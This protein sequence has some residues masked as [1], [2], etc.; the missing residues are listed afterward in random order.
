MRFSLTKKIF[1]GYL[2]LIS[3]LLA[4][5]GYGGVT[6]YQ[7]TGEYLYLV[8][9]GVPVQRD[10]YALEELFRLQTGNEQKFYVVGSP[11]IAERFR[12]QD[13]EFEQLAAVLISQVPTPAERDA[14]VRVLALHQSYSSA[15]M[16]NMADWEAGGDGP[17]EVGPGYDT[18]PLIEDMAVGLKALS[19]I[20]RETRKAHLADTQERG[21][22]AAGT[23]LVLALLAVAG[24]LAA[25][26]G[27]SF[28]L[29]RPVWRLKAATEQ[30]ALGIFDRKVPVES[31][32]EI[33]DL[34]AAFNRMAAKLEGLDEVRDEFITYVSHELKTPLTSLKEATSLLQD[35]IAGRITSRQH[36]LLGIIQEDCSKIERLISEMLDLSKMEAGMMPFVKERCAFGGIVLAAVE[37]MEPVAHNRKIHIEA[38]GPAVDVVVDCSRIRQVIT[39]LISNAI[40]FSPERAHVTVSWEL[41]GT[42]VHCRV[43]DQGPGIPELARGRIF[44]KFHQLAP[45]ELS[46][47]RGSGLGLPIARRIV[48]SH[49]GQIWVECPEGEGS[50]F[51]FTLPRAPI[52]KKAP[53][54]AAPVKKKPAAPVLP[55]A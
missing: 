9:T 18:A 11:D 7:L 31:N 17:P 43:A 36:Q 27:L 44:E 45:S 4:I 53:Q 37:E 38:E 13:T 10:L 49:A 54:P 50:V 16:A 12:A 3:L 25:A 51:H 46:G 39:N 28:F 29:T 20:V 1:G 55:S 15:V 24:G 48:T 6:L 26:L 19:R 47:L 5:A 42:D 22:R 8:E 35:G 40:K 34:A 2:V 30:V 41:S 14:V 52:L 23:T 21:E 32:D 33:G